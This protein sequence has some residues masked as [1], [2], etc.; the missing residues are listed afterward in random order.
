MLKTAERDAGYSMNLGLRAV[1]TGAAVDRGTSAFVPGL[2]ST[3]TATV[4]GA[5]GATHQEIYGVLFSSAFA[6]VFLCVDLV[7]NGLGGSLQQ[8]LPIEGTC[9]SEPCRPHH[10]SPLDYSGC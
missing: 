8:Q 7:L 1:L 5:R 2:G 10:V 4:L 3:L 6:A 9:C